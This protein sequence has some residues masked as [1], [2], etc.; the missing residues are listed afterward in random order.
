MQ[1]EIKTVYLERAL[2]A[3]C[4]KSLWKS[5]TPSQKKKKNV[6]LVVFWGLHTKEQM[7]F[8]QVGPNSHFHQKVAKPHDPIPLGSHS[9]VP[10][11]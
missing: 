2:P 11:A 5:F 9:T 4:Y 3:W 6:I 1:N 7:N 10:W 8:E